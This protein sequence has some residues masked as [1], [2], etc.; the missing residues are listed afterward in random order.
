[1]S[2]T[3]TPNHPKDQA[4]K[5]AEPPPQM[6]QQEMQELLSL[7]REKAAM[8]QI[9]WELVT[10]VA[11]DT[12]HI[13]VS[14]TPS[15]PLWQLAFVQ[16]SD[17]KSGKI[18]ILAGTMPAITEQEKRRVVRLLRSTSTPMHTALAQ[19]EIPHPPSYVEKQIE[20][21]L[22]WRPAEKGEFNPAGA[23]GVWESVKAPSIGE[24]AK[25]FLGFP[26]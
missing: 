4:S 17:A 24:K 16:S 10:Q 20:A 25:N 23:T 11:P 15:D 8:S 9:L 13:E 21:H 1:M 7:R 3:P 14:P 22:K 18:R 2:S 12:H 26:K 6:S 19:L 5:P